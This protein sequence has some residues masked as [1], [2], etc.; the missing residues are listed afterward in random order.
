MIVRKQQTARNGEIV[1]AVVDEGNDATL[2][3]YYREASR[4]RLQP[5][6]AS[7]QPIYADNV[8]IRGVVTG[9]IRQY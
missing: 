5:A 6:N 7:M 3:R 9:V 2:K 8:E 1:V 4:V